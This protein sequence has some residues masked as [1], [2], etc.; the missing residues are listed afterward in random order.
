MLAA[1][2]KGI[3]FAHRPF[4]ELSREIG[5]AESELLDFARSVLKSGNARRFG[6]VF[7]T[8]RLGYSSALCCATVSEPDVAAK[9]LVD[10][11]E[12]THCY[13]REAPGC[14]NL[15][16]TWSAPTEKFESSLLKVD[17][18]FS[19]LP[20][21]VRYKVDVMFGVDT[22]G[23]EESTVDNL[24]PPDGT[25][26]EIIRAL[27]GDTEIRSDYYS[28][29]AEKAGMKEWDL[30]SVLEIWHRQGRLK[31]IGLL[32]NHRKAGYTAN[33]MCCFRIG[34]DTGAAGR[35]LAELAE[36]THCYERPMCKEFPYNLYAMVHG[37][38]ICETESKFELLKSRLAGLESPPSGSVMLISQKEYKKT[39]MS[40]YP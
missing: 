40:F 27:Q 2:Q 11:T 31:R 39:S 1:L 17:I 5:C 13:L 15:W 24:P 26:R 36:V 22:R 25:G 9:K 14:P 34:G 4:E 20:A 7:D 33:G 21:S 3:P 10:F 8:R 6:A 32:L 16:W 12:I 18:P 30:L 37:T 23:A 29:I 19:V 28:A 35:A 38:S